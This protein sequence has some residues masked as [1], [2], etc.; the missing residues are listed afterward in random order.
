MVMSEH[1]G[2]RLR[3]G[4]DFDEVLVAARR[5]D[6][7][8]FRELYDALAGRV[9]GYLSVHGASDAEDLTS[10]VFLRAF[11]GLE[12]FEGN[13]RQFRSWVFTIAHH[14][15]LDD[16][17]RRGA[18]ITTSAFDSDAANRVA[19]GDVEDE[20]IEHLRSEWVT[21]ALAHLTPDQQTVVT[22][23]VVGDL[24]VEQVAVVIGK[25]AGAVK[26]LQ[27]RG[28]AALRRNMAGA[29]GEVGEGTVT[30]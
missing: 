12:R 24:S 10:E 11:R 27:R 20:A 1:P 14:L 17:R 2:V 19:G 18:R 21:D 6:P 23:R 30:R 25:P 28:I 16:R 5:G 15:L 7:L 4:L 29:V 8:A 13:E 22:L 9:C 26:A 3:P